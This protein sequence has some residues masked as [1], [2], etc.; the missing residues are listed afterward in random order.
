MELLDWSKAPRPGNFRVG[1]S[2]DS[3][4]QTPVA[5]E[6][7]M[8]QA[9]ILADTLSTLE[10]YKNKCQALESTATRLRQTVKALRKEKEQVEV[11]AAQAEDQAAQHQQEV[12][13]LK[14]VLHLLSSFL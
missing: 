1:K 3:C 9:C 13:E 11:Q 10:E 8:P 6:P 5:S 4:W 7:P 14:E 12:T 2:H